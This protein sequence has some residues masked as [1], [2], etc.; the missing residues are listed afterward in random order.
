MPQ[1]QFWTNQHPMS[2]RW[3]YRIDL[4]EP[5]SSPLFVVQ[6]KDQSDKNMDSGQVSIPCNVVHEEMADLLVS[7]WEA[8]L[9]G[10]LGDVRQTVRTVGTKWKAEA[11]QR[12]R[13]SLL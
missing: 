7:S 8:Y 1:R 3:E 4:K 12:G 10:E 6:V 2:V 11:R 13:Q 5:M 9:F